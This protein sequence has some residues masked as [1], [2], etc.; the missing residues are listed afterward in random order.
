MTSASACPA[1]G[2]RRLVVFHEVHDVPVSSCL[3]VGDRAQAL[4]F[5]RGDLRLGRCEDCGFIT[6]TAFD[7]SRTAYSPDYEETQGFSP[8]FQAFIRDL[9]RDWV[10][11]FGLAGKH[12]VEIGCGKGEFVVEMLRAGAGSALGIDPGVHPERVPD[13]VQDRAA[14]I[15]GFFPDSLPELVADAVV[16]RHTLEHILH[17]TRDASKRLNDL[18]GN[19]F[20]NRFRFRMPNHCSP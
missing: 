15:R 10:D 13:D 14:W 2:S 3:L 20:R 18:L 12:V 1:C 16:C 11:R 8:H 5:P 6:N 4:A 7:P 9:S 17:L 19:L